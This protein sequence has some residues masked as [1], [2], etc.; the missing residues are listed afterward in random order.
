MGIKPVYGISVE[1]QMS[2]ILVIED[3]LTVRE[4]ICEIL[5]A[6]KFDVFSAEDGY[7]GVQL[8]QEK[9]PDLILCDIMMPVLNGY[10]VLS[11]LR[12]QQTTA[13]TP[14]IFIT[15]KASNLDLR[16]GMALGADDYITKPFT[17]DDLLGAVLARLDR[18]TAMMRNCT[19][20]QYKCKDLEKKVHNLQ[21]F[22]E[23]RE[24]I[25]QNFSENL[26]NSVAKI[27]MAIHMMRNAPAGVQR[28]RYLEI[29]QA[30][31][32][33]EINLLNEVTELRNFLTPENFSLLRQYKLL[34]NK[35]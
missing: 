26:R 14:F 32:D 23:N 22:T 12:K 30:E 35:N 25:F 4:I 20:D 6:E 10:E 13:V 16:Q 24:E 18:Q 27:N 29:L 33:S 5:I 21:Q 28:D 3:E 31:C 11:E 9:S 2:K 7:S 19:I 34:K 1:K 8:A 15:A 17:K